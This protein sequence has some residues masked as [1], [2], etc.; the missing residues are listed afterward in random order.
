[1]GIPSS[2]ICLKIL[3]EVPCNEN[4]EHYWDH[5]VECAVCF[6]Q[7]RGKVP[8]LSKGN[9]AHKITADEIFSIKEIL[10]SCVACPHCG[11]AISRAS[12]CNHIL[13]RNCDKSFCYSCGK[14]LNEDHTRYSSDVPWL[15]VICQVSSILYRSYSLD[16]NSEPMFPFWKW[17][18]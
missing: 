18:M 14:A 13:C 2:I 11:F 10:R 3:S 4:I 6:V 8:N 9:A 17:T 12:G 15:S 5:N 7:E 1:M 16:A